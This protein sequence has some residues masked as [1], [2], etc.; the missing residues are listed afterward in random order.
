MKRHSIALFSMMCLVSLGHAQEKAPAAPAPPPVGTPQQL[1]E[2]LT[3]WETAMTAV[4]TFA[5]DLKRVEVNN[6]WKRTE[7]WTGVAR[8]MRVQA[9]SQASNLAFLHQEN[10]ERKIWERY[11]NTG[12]FLYQY[13]PKDAEI[14]VHTLPKPK[15]GQ[16][17]ED[18]FL[19]F[20]FG[21]KADVARQRFDLVLHYPNDPNWVVVHVKPRHDSDRVDFQQARLVLDRKTFLPKQLW[22][23]Q[24]AGDQVTWEL[25]KVATNIEIDRKTF[26]PE[27]NGWKVTKV[28]PKPTEAAPRVVRPSQP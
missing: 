19:S 2:V 4:S 17:A 3:K 21:M 9:G 12:E 20:L 8:Y 1:A 18:S 25:E 7:V 22:F 16:P 14:R 15:P 13:V 10:K 11:I 6:T 28:T 27:T 24:P 23:E 26:V 5:A